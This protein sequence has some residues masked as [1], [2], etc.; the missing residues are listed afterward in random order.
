MPE[1]IGK[2]GRSW[3]IFL[4]NN[5]KLGRLSMFQSCQEAQK[6]L[7]YHFLLTWMNVFWTADATMNPFLSIH[8]KRFMMQT[9]SPEQMR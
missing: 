5:N 9:R 3:P 7:V 4:K 6:D 2:R 8:L 1:N